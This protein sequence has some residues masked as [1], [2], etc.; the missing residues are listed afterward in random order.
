VCVCLD[1][2]KLTVT[3]LKQL[4]IDLSRAIVDLNN[5]LRQELATSDE[6]KYENQLSRD[7]ITLALNIQRKR[8]QQQISSTAAAA[9][10]DDSD[11]SADCDSSGT[12]SKIIIYFIFT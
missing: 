6:L 7:F 11:L 5:A 3:E 10:D 1:L 4:S 8:R 2:K 12:V 9:D